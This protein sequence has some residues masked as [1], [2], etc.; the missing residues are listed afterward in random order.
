[1]S[2]STTSPLLA[3][4]DSPFSS[5]QLPM[6]FHLYFNFLLGARNPTCLATRL[7][8]LLAAIDESA[9]LQNIAKNFSHPGGETN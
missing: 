9:E 5:V 3:V 6:Y 7:D 2:L 8:R 4:C 1:M